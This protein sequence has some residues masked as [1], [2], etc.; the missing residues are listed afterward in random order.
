ML[1]NSPEGS[2]E[3]TPVTIGFYSTHTGA[4]EDELQLND[5]L[6]ETMS[7]QLVCPP[8]YWCKGGKR[9]HCPAGTFGW[10]WGLTHEACSGSCKCTQRNAT[11]HNATQR[12][13]VVFKICVR[14]IDNFLCPV[15]VVSARTV[16]SS[17]LL[18]PKPPGSTEHPRNAGGVRCRSGRHAPPRSICRYAAYFLR[19]FFFIFKSAC[20]VIGDLCTPFLRAP[21]L[22]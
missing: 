20:F 5:P 4:Y 18:L 3:P 19:A 21:L 8:G 17:W 9:F 13:C 15:S 11:Q 16:T 12:A 1:V 14:A 7:A 6:N 10:T 2:S 22:L